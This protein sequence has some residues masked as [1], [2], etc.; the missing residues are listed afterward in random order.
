MSSLTSLKTGFPSV[1]QVIQSV[2]I[3]ELVDLNWRRKLQLN[4]FQLCGQV[5]KSSEHSQRNLQGRA[6]HGFPSQRYL[7]ANG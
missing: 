1:Y 4:I 7:D 3:V 5:P 6:R 2:H